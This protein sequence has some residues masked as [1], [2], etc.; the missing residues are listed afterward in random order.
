MKLESVVSVLTTPELRRLYEAVEEQLERAITIEKQIILTSQKIIIDEYETEPCDEVIFK[1]Y[2]HLFGVTY[3]GEMP[4]SSVL[5]N[6]YL[7]SDERPSAKKTKQEKNSQVKELD[8]IYNRRYYETLKIGGN[9]LIYKSK[10][11]CKFLLMDLDESEDWPNTHVIRF[12][13]NTYASDEPRELAENLLKLAEV[14][15]FFFEKKAAKIIENVTGSKQSD[16]SNINVS[17]QPILSLLL[18]QLYFRA[19]KR[20]RQHRKILDQVRSPMHNSKTVIFVDKRLMYTNIEGCYLG[21]DVGNKIID[22]EAP[23]FQEVIESL[24]FTES[25]ASEIL[26]QSQEDG[27]F[28]PPSKRW[29]IHVDKSIE[30]VELKFQVEASQ[31]FGVKS[32]DERAVLDLFAMVVKIVETQPDT[33]KNFKSQKTLMFSKSEDRIREVSTPRVEFN[34]TLN[35]SVDLE[36]PEFNILDY[37][38][39]ETTGLVYKL[40]MSRF[41]DMNLE[42]EKLREFVKEVGFNYEANNNTFHNIYHAFTVLHGAHTLSKSPVFASLFDDDTTFTFLIAALCHDICHTGVTNQFEEKVT[43]V[44]ANRYGDLSILENNSIAKTLDLLAQEETDFLAHMSEKKW[45]NF[46]KLLVEAILATD[47]QNHL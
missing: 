37:D 16:I 43:S 32:V 3:I 47:N 11:K 20:N 35:F 45:K 27:L 13:F 6:R 38:I 28:Q 42:T 41:G 29:S 46:R 44:L 15:V 7:N 40:L 30:W 26:R 33:I 18:N 21:K 9:R 2:N 17:G 1:L 4:P 19:E 23:G 25:D 22:R 39:H 10:C 31:S 8:R 14:F 36:S 5:L 12:L 34:M 24:E